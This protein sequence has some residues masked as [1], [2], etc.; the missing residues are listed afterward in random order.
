MTPI[1][2]LCMVLCY[3]FGGALALMML[4]MVAAVVMIAA[5]AI[6]G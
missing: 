3:V 5:I 6:G 1:E 2:R 4:M